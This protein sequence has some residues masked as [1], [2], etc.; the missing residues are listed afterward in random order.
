[1]RSGPVCTTVYLASPAQPQ[2]TSRHMML[3]LS[4]LP[5]RAAPAVLTGLYTP[6]LGEMKSKLARSCG[7]SVSGS[8]VSRGPAQCDTWLLV[9]EILLPVEPC[10]AVLVWD[11]TESCQCL[12]VSGSPRVFS[13]DLV[14]AAGSTV[15]AL[16]LRAR[17][18]GDFPSWLCGSG[19]FPLGG[20][21]LDLNDEF[22][23]SGLD[24]TSGGAGPGGGSWQDLTG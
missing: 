3:H 6:A 1:M 2:P 20:G 18:V 11:F 15:M 7:L 17:S 4:F 19:G 16:A 23:V 8:S 24:F 22:R 5:A 14:E 13:L 10:E 21:M 9:E 12:P